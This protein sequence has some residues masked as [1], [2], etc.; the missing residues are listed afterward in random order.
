MIEYQYA[1]LFK[2]DK[3]GI[4]LNIAFDGGKFTNQDIP[5]EKVELS[6]SICSENMLRFG[7]CESSVFKVQIMNNVLPLAGKV[8]TVSETLKDGEGELFALGS[9]GVASDKPTTDRKYRD[10]VAYDAMYDIIHADAAKV[11]AWYNSLVFPMTLKAFRS[12]FLSWMGIRQEDVTLVNDGMMVEKTLDSPSELPGLT[13]MTAICELNG[14]F[15]HIG[16]NGKFQYIIL[17]E[18]IPGLYPSDD[19]YPSDKLHPADPAGAEQ[20]G[21]SYYRSCQYEDFKTEKITGVQIRQEENDIGGFS[22][23][24]G[25]IYIV[26]D[27]FLVYGKGA[28]ELEQIAGNMLSV[29]GRVSY[30]PATVTAKGNPCLEV[31]DGIRLNTDREIVYTYILQRTLK[32][33]QALTDTY[34]AA[35]EK[36]Q[37][38][39]APSLRQELLKLKGRTNTL[40]RTVEENRLEVKDIEKNLST[41]I[42]QTAE[43]IRIEAERAAAAEGSMSAQIA[44]N[45]QQILAKVSRDSLIAEINMSPEKVKIKAPKIDLEGLV[46]APELVSKF[47][48]IVSLN[49]TNQA[50]MEKASI[51]SLNAV[52][53]AVENLKA[54]KLSA[55][56]F[57]AANISAMD[58][59]VRAARIAGKVTASQIDA[60]NLKVSAANIT[61]SLDV[62]TL[63][64]KWQQESV[65]TYLVTEDVTLAT[66]TG[67]KALATRIKEV[68]TGTMW[69]LGAL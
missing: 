60:T 32:G 38:N 5:L 61:G 17:K 53:A 14:A 4:K 45:A 26:Q 39:G 43:S 28:A 68:H 49:V 40:I 34:E 20:I 62:G 13:V 51:S 59:S 27:N 6:E 69:Y 44:L 2:R 18:L 3:A 8:L 54:D 21:R 58:I 25:N 37:S 16:R 36:R 50:V 31:G 55:G 65:V 1:D 33:I 52:N 9:Y 23:T 66:P 46:N 15:G 24:G 56:E 11:A 42:V 63:G 22:G 29:I 48:T 10:I 47:A 7:S 35:G 12:S 19:L 41:S 67:G 64:A 30:R 57:N